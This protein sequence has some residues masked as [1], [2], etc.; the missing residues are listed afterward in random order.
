M[1]LPSCLHV[2]QRRYHLAFLSLN[3]LK[4]AE[5]AY[6][7]ISARAHEVDM[8]IKW[9]Y[10]IGFWKRSFIPS[11][12]YMYSP[13]GKQQNHHFLWRLLE[14]FALRN[15]R[16]YLCKSTSCNLSKLTDL[17]HTQAMKKEFITNFGMEQSLW[18]KCIIIDLRELNEGNARNN[19]KY[20][21]ECT[22]IPERRAMDVCVVAR[23]K[24]P[25]SYAESY[26][27]VHWMQIQRS[28]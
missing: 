24:S 19:T 13:G 23:A 11:M 25:L 4:M 9:N 22:A 15:W 20:I 14:G 18:V 8:G 3:K 10:P 21:S 28:A 5:I 16:I 12:L 27:Y 17:F 2:T 1:C 7:I 26:S 6:T